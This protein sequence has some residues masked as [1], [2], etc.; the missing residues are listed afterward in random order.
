MLTANRSPPDPTAVQ[1]V[2]HSSESPVSYPVT[3]LKWEPWA[4]SNTGSANAVKLLSTSDCLR[5]WDYDVANGKLAQRCALINKSKSEFMAPLTSFDW[6]KTDPSLVITSSVDTTCTIW[7]INR[8]VAKTQLIAHDN[9]VYDVSFVANSVDVFSSVG[10]DG[11]VRIF[12]LR[13]LDH[14]TIIYE[15]VDP[16]PLLRIEAN[17][18]DKNIL[19]TIAKNSNLIQI[20]DIRSPGVPVATLNAHQK[21]VNSI[22]W[23][24]PGAKA[25]QNR[26]VIAS[27]GDDCQV[28][29]WDLSSTPSGA[30][31]PRSAFTDTAEV[32][33]IV[34][35][36]SANWVGVVSGRSFQ[37]VRLI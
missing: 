14:S 10:A 16:V 31:C 27:G 11:S 37:G 2:R 26:H 29:V 35:S 28:L 1:D 5:I 13:S 34:W 32:N 24:P 4:G 8:S 6:N 30:H 33:N 19:A 7:D 20:L 17:P 12:D 3:K 9:E 25:L 21:T 36:P 22:A 15:P 23:V 18:Y